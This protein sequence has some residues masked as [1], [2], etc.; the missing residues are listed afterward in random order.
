MPRWLANSA[1]LS[2]RARCLTLCE[3][4][5]SRGDS[6]VPENSL[7]PEP[8]A[9]GHLHP[10]G[11][12]SIFALTLACLGIYGVIAYLVTQRYKEIGIRLALGATRQN[13][14]RLILARTLKLT[15]AGI[16]AGLIAAF[17]LSRFLSSILFGITVHD[18]VTFIAVPACLIV[19]ALL[20]GY[21]PARRATRV[22]PVTSLRYE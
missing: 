17:F 4:R 1:D 19:I 2:R 15:T 9:P 22:D 3:A 14:L 18:T 16:L 8:W 21:L 7:A 5:K 6:E 11:V 12:F 13:I 10:L 20:A